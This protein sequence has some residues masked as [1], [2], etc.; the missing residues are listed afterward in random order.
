MGRRHEASVIEGY[1][2]S[3]RT[4]LGMPGREDIAR[5][6]AHHRMG[7]GR[8]PGLLLQPWP[9]STGCA[10]RRLLGRGGALVD[11]VRRAPTWPACRHLRRHQTHRRPSRCGPTSVT[12]C[13]RAPAGGRGRRRRSRAAPGRLRRMSPSAR[14]GASS[15]TWPPPDR[16]PATAGQPA[17]RHHLL[18]GQLRGHA[19]RGDPGRDPPLRPSA[20][21]IFAH[22]RDIRGSRAAA[23]RRPSTT[24]ARPTWP[25]PCAPT[26]TWATTV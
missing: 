25:R 21:K 7:R 10:P 26:S 22:F 2:L 20:S 14:S 1:Q 8:H 5:M 3:D 6:R 4:P 13:K 16:V 9:Y 15:A 19:G 18:P 11:A 17:Q 24:R 12:S 23:S